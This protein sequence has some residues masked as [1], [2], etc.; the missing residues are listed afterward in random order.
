MK[1]KILSSSSGKH[2]EL[3]DCYKSVISYGKQEFKRRSHL[4]VPTSKILN[5]EYLI[6]YKPDAIILDLEDSIPNSHKEIARRLLKEELAEVEGVEIIIRINKL[7]DSE[8]KK[9]LKT[10]ET[11]KGLFHSI[12]IP[13]VED[14]KKVESVK[15]TFH[16]KSIYVFFETPMGL[17]NCSAIMKSLDKGK[18]FVG[19]GAGDIC[20]NFGIKRIPIYDSDILKALFSKLAI[21][22]HA[23]DLDII[24]TISRPYD[25]KKAEDILKKEGHW[26]KNNIGAIGKRAIHPSQLKIINEIFS[27]TKTELTLEIDLLNRFALNSGTR[28]IGKPGFVYSGTPEYLTAIK[29]V[30]RWL[31]CGFLKVEVPRKK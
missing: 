21:N 27:P 11:I 6:K 9:D 23:N 20:M 8:S 1:L 19:L 3:N 5:L 30:N 28:A 16:D 2:L 25:T 15:K 10:L 4:F 13:K 31:K 7:G 17:E 24:D 22:A 29:N 12:S 18:D 14:V 26:T